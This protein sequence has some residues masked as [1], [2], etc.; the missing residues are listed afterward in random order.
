[1]I[2]MPSHI[3]RRASTEQGYSLVELMIAML[4]TTVIMGA[5]M[6]GLSDAIRAND[7]VLHITG[8]I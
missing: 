1:M 8:M 4:V 2:T 5:T 3:R 6:S 7:A